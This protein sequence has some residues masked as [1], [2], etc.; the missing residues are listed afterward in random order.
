MIIR[1]K[2]GDALGTGTLRRNDPVELKFIGEKS[3]PLA[4]FGVNVRN[5]RKPDGSWDSEWIN[6]KAWGD[7]AYQA[8]GLTPGAAIFFSGRMETRTFTARDGG[9]KSV[10]ECRIDFVTQS[11]I[12]GG[13]PESAAATTP[14]APRSAVAHPVDVAFTELPDDGELPF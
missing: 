10:E 1:L 9:E 7:A 4:T 11:F 2:N 13:D 14:A 6:C 3:T 8:A 12:G 5:L